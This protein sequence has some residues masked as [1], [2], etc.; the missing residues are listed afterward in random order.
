[1]ANSEASFKSEFKKA[2]FQYYGKELFMW[3]HTDWGQSG[4]PD[5]AILSQSIYMPIEAKFVIQPPARDASKLL[6]RELTVPQYDH[7]EE[8]NRNGGAAHVFI[9]F[10]DVAVLVP[11]CFWPVKEMNVTYGFVKK[12]STEYPKL[13]FKKPPGQWSVGGFLESARMWRTRT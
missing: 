6:K 3:S 8:A 2:L 11:F 10:P 7:L 13:V 4:L 5:W 12:L 9:G 1:V